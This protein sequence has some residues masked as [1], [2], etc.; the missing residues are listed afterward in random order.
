MLMDGTAFAI[1]CANPLVVAD[2][3]LWIYSKNVV[4]VQRPALC[5][6]SV[7]WLFKYNAIAPPARNECEP[8]SDF[9]KRRF[10]SRTAGIASFTTFTMSVLR[11][12]C[13]GNDGA[14]LNAQISVSWDA[15]SRT[16]SRARATNAFT[17]QH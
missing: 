11:I 5:I 13:H 4:L 15:P 3:W 1:D 10:P 8:T 16:M 7:E 12:C 6:S 17:A 9:S 2:S 14:S